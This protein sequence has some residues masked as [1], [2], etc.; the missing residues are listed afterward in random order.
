MIQKHFKLQVKEN[1][2][3]RVKWKIHFPSKCGG[4]VVINLYTPPKLI[5]SNLQYRTE[6]NLPIVPKTALKEIL[7][8]SFGR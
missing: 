3:T 7:F 1:Y 4:W 2:G 5:Y 6:A 8:G